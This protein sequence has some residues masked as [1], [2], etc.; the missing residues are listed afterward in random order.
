M[1][2][3][4]VMSLAVLAASSHALFDLVVFEPDKVVTVPTSGTVTITWS[5]TITTSDNFVLFGNPVMTGLYLEDSLIG[6]PFPVLDPAMDDFTDT[7]GYGDDY[8]GNLFSITIGPDTL[9]GYYGYFRDSSDVAYMY[10]Q[11]QDN[12][13]GGFRDTEMVSVL[14]QPVPEPAS[15]VLLGVGA[16]ALLRRRRSRKSGRHEPSV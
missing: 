7:N 5:G 2:W 13:F 15:I 10:A 12:N 16:A 8:S 3:F 9:P 1:K 4:A 14:V 11:G 6:L